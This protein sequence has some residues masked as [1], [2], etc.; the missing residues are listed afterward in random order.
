MRI[1]IDATPLLLRGGG[2]KNYVYHWLRNLRNRSVDPILAFPFLRELGALDHEHSIAS[3]LGTFA[4]L[5]LIRFANFG[6]NPVLNLLG[7][8]IE[9]FHVSNSN[10]S[11]PPKNTRLSVT[12]YDMTCWIVPG[13]HRPATVNA[14]RMFA[15][16]VVKRA[17]G[18]IAISESTRQDAI[19]IL[20]LSPDKVRV[21]YPGI[22]D[23]FF[24][25]PADCVEQVRMKY[26]LAREYILFV[27]TIEPRKNLGRLVESYRGLAPS[28]QQEFDLVIAGPEGWIEPDDLQRIR[29][30]QAGVRHLGYVPEADLP[31]L[32]AGATIAAYPS[33]YEGFGFP[34]VQAMAAGVPVVT[35]RTSSLPEVTG[36]AAELVDPLSVGQIRDALSRLLLSPDLRSALSEKGRQRARDYTWDRC[37]RMSLNYFEALVGRQ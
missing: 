13:T 28:T 37:A 10:I 23:A 27:G 6:N 7:R 22:S 11:N 30:P 31:A 18:V 9:L 34:V 3:P 20:G 2:V 12:L 25:V 5:A 35:S 24:D 8:R 29:S 17:D 1:M 15:E 14:T 19:K 16:R 21:I 36:D 4:R 33:L 32:T 26:G